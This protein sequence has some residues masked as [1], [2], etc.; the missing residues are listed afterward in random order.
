MKMTL[1]VFLHFLMAGNCFA[2]YPITAK[3]KL[4]NG[5][6][7]SRKAELTE[8][9]TLLRKKHYQVSGADS[10]DPRVPKIE[11][12]NTVDM[13]NEENYSKIAIF[14]APYGAF[15]TVQYES[16]A[17]LARFIPD[18]REPLSAFIERAFTQ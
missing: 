1:I 7:A 11:L 5:S 12:M 18:A 14:T 17:E 6:I 13:S 9:Q 8:L 4:F 3:M 15:Q 2:S 10:H 16:I